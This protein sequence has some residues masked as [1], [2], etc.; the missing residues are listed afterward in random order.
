MAIQLKSP[1]TPWHFILIFFLFAIGIGT[2]G[3]FYYEIQKQHMKIEKQNELLAIAD[4]KTSQITNWRKERMSNAEVILENPSAFHHFQDC[5]N[6]KEMSLRQGVSSWMESLCKRSDY[7]SI[8]LLDAKGRARLSVTVGDEPVGSYIQTFAVEATKTKKVILTDLYRD[9]TTRHIHI[10]ILIP[11]APRDR[12]RSP[13]GVLLIRIDPEQFLYPLIQTWPT[14]SRT[15]ESL[16]VRREGDEVVFLNELRHRKN[17]ALS[18]RIPISEQQMPAVMG[19]RGIEGIVE[20]LDYRGVKVL[21]AVRAIP[22]SPWYLIAKIDQEEI[23]APIRE[24][25]WFAIILVG[26]L[27]LAAGVG[28]GFLWR[29]KTAQFYQKQYENEIERQALTRHYEHL[30]KYANDIIFLADQN[31]KIVE[32]N[33]R[34]LASY[35][36]T[37]DEFLKMDAKSL[38]SP[39]E[40]QLFDKQFTTIDEQKGMILETVHQRQDGITFPVE[41][42]IR[43]IEVEGKKFY[44]SIIRDIT[45]RKQA[46]KEREK[47]IQ[48]LQEALT[49]VKK[50]SGLL[51]ICASCKKIRDD[52]GY[53]NQIEGYIRD[54]SE[55]EFS[56]GICPECMKKLYPDL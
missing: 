47:L 44:Q 25:A 56:H 3:Y 41:A 22:G 48:E 17:T 15:A 4:L 29:H 9:E 26:T 1:K 55:A 16:L 40:K 18:L 34:A 13:S 45:R 6:T 36:Y 14:P 37:R 49:K 53:W 20:G 35:G 31:W 46:E 30:T 21:A 51:P 38:R 12:I 54:H 23:Y 39:E 27:I 10:D 5:L 33:D 19:M 28:V 50:L 11:L 8:F 2:A 7:N 42:S 32:A 24:H 43:V 52:K